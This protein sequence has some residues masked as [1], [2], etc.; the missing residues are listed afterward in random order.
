MLASKQTKWDKTA[1]VVVIG[2]G[3]AGAVAAITAKERGASA[4]ILEKQAADDYCSCS[5]ISGGL[6]ICPTD[7]KGAEQY[8]KALCDVDG[9]MNWTDSDT[10]QAWAEYT[11]QNREWME[12]LGG[13]VR[14]FLHAADYPQFPGADSIEVWVY[15]GGGVRLMEFM[16][17]QLKSR[18]IEVMYQA[19]AERLLINENGAVIGVKAIDNRGGQRRDVNIRAS[20]AVILC[21][22]GF[23]ANKE[24]K[25]QYLRV[26]PV[27]FGGGIANTGD[28]I[29]MAQ[30]VGADL[31]H[32]N[33]CS[34]RLI[35]KFPDFP[36]SFGIDFGGR[37]WARRQIRGS[38]E[39]TTNGFIIVNRYGRR[40]MTEIINF[41]SAI[42]ELTNF[43]TH[44][45]EYPKVPSYH[46]FDRKRMQDGPL[47]QRTSGPAG[48]QQLYA[49]SRDN[50]SE[51]K[52]GW[53]TSANT[54][55]ELAG[56]LG[57][58]PEVLKKTIRVWNR[59]CKAGKD[60]EFGR[61]PND[62]APINTPPYYAVR[63]IPGGPNTQGGPRRNAKAQ[64]VNPFGE[65]IPGLYGA[66]ECGS[67]YG[68]LYP[69]GGGN[70]AECIAFGRIAGE[71][72]A[73]EES[74]A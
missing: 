64:V 17:E 24:M 23:E 58:G 56:K 60:P 11:V 67:L 2:C 16:R 1:E 5:S 4:I 40:Y 12:K 38:T 27:N 74:K 69:I 51:L 73:K 31:W 55:G 18:N 48:P 15:Q 14:L 52:R 53:I 10:I 41:H 50:L 49:W 57:M 62:L 21:S 39:K 70:L 45:L 19:P 59:Y 65:P 20:K 66:G 63:L 46:I 37:G 26:Y 71:N 47:C 33:C 61:N 32:M 54:I 7:R 6:F 28:G 68:M 3:L 35:A 43:D 30:E 13:N 34:A 72:A 8:V 22:G 9:E 25:L 44:K 36:L 29:K 42:Y